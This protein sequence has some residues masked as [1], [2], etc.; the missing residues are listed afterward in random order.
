MLK[1]CKNCLKL[2]PLR[3]FISRKIN[4]KGTICYT[5]NCEE[6]RN[7]NRQYY[8]KKAEYVQNIRKKQKCKYCGINDW[9]VLQSD[10]YRGT[11]VGNISELSSIKRIDKELTKTQPLC[12]NCHAK[13]TKLRRTDTNQKKNRKRNNLRNYS[14]KIKLDRGCEMCGLDQQRD[15]C[16]YVF[17]HTDEG[18][19]NKIDSIS[20]L[21]TKNVSLD[22]LNA[23]ISKCRVLCANCHQIRTR[24]Q[25][26]WKEWSKS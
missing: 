19:K 6:C 20:N 2:K 26:C 13:I 5:N 24:E 12:C 3:R 10:H 15:P 17:D 8:N 4:S 21:I 14:D 7:K 22:L 23:E 16:I 18:S 1:K 11:K 9:R 25:L